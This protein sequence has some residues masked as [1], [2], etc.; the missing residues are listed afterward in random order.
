M[1]QASPSTPE[2][3]RAAARDRAAAL[4]LLRNS[5]RFL[6]CGHVRPDGDC[7]GAQAALASVLERLGKEVWIENTDPLPAQLDYLGEGLKFRVFEGGSLPAHD[8]AVM[9]DFNE[10]E[11]TG[12]MKAPLEA[13]GSRKLVID[14]HIAHGAPW[15]NAAYVDVKAAATGLLVRRIAREL[16][17]PL[18]LRAA[19]GVYTSLVTDTGWFK[20]SNTDAETFAAAA[21]AVAL[22][23]APSELFN[24]IYQ[25]QSRQQPLGLARALGRLEYFADGRLAVVDLP[26]AQP[27]EVDLPDGDDLLDLLRAVARVEVVLFLRELKDGSLKLSA[28]SKTDYDVNK[29]ARAF[30]GGGHAK[31]SGATLR[32]TLPEMRAKLVEAAVKLF[33]DAAR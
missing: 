22:G 23:V 28:R 26:L 33:A 29:L 25:R 31:A 18:D 3:E 30:G 4:D 8:V 2:L 16:G 17:V 6:L 9:L 15:W 10:L 27:G 7:L 19:R 1:T 13:A 24:S 5:Q 11:R 20:Y 32:G 21:E 14:H 12:A